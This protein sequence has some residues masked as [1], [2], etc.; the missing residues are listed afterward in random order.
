MAVGFCPRLRLPCGFA[1]FSCERQAESGFTNDSAVTV[2]G[3]LLLVLHGGASVKMPAFGNRQAR[4]KNIAAY[5]ALALDVNSVCRMD[6]SDD[7][8]ADNNFTHGDIAGQAP[9]LTDDKA[10]GGDVTLDDAVHF[11]SAL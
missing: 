2:I 4:R 1:L 11:N 5:F 7:F 6:V 8:S 10:V 9:R 3:D